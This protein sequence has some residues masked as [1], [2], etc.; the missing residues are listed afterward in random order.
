MYLCIFVNVYVYT[1]I[2]TYIY[3]YI[4]IYIYY[5]SQELSF[6]E[7]SKILVANF[8]SGDS[9]DMQPEGEQYIELEGA[10]IYVYK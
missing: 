2:N 3:I 8:S 1:Y 6:K 10:Y 4:Y 7:I 9:F 5:L